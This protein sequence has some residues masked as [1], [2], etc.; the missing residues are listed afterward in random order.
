[1]EKLIEIKRQQDS[2]QASIRFDMETNS[3]KN[4]LARDVAEKEKMIRYMEMRYQYLENM[5]SKMEKQQ[6]RPRRQSY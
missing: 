2:S 4:C 1:V 6:H 5:I 3:Q